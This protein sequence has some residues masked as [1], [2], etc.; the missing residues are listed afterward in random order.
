MFSKF[1]FRK[2]CRLWD[3]VEKYGVA[4]QATDDNIIRRMRSVCWV[5]TNTDTHSKYVVIIAFPRQQWLHERPSMLRYT[6]IACLV[7][8]D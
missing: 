6:Y 4:T 2:S 1:F 7:I 3:N 8:R 5:P